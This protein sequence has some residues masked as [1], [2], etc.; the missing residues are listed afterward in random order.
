[1]PQVPHGSYG[2][3][4]VLIHR[5]LEAVYDIYVCTLYVYMYID[6]YIYTSSMCME[7]LM[8]GVYLCT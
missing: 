6:R 1:M 3:A 7:V 2:D 8:Y 5:R 4:V